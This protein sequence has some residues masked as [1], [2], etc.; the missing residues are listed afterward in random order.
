[1]DI[2]LNL[3]TETVDQCHPATPLC[4][5]LATTASEAVRAMKESSRGS[6]LV[7]RDEVV[8]GIFTERDVLKMMAAGASFNVPIEQVMTHDPVVLRAGDKV[9]RAI[10]LMAQGGYRRLPIVDD[11]GRAI[12][13]VRVSGILHYLAEHFPTVIY[14]LP[15]EPHH[16]TQQREG[17]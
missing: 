7:C 9:G 11:S 17:A 3:N 15:P 4:V 5:T 6:V 16:S 14:N 1:M 10:T 12:G 2:R 8:I 13:V